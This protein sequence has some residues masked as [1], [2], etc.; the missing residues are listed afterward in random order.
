MFYESCYITKPLTSRVANSERYLVCCKFK[1]HNTQH[2]LPLWKSMYE[3]IESGVSVKGFLNCNIPY[4]F[5]NKILVNKPQLY[6]LQYPYN[7]T[8]NYRHRM[9]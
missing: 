5:S 2:L 6:Y 7:K 9:L 1:F 4:Y 3:K 8:T